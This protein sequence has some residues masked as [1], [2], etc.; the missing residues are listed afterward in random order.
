MKEWQIMVHKLS[1]PSTDVEIEKD[2][3]KIKKK[4]GQEV[5]IKDAISTIE[6][7]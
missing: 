5:G 4:L 1:G 7:K 3:K 2:R 6:I